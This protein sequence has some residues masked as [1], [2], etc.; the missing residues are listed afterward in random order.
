MPVC[1]KCRHEWSWKDS[2]K[3]VLWIEMGSKCPNCGELQYPTTKSRQR[4]LVP[5]VF[6]PIPIILYSIF[7]YPFMMGMLLILLLL[8]FQLVAMPFFVELTDEQEPLW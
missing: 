4:M 7:D 5:S 6:V 8:A 2:M 1:S 3:R